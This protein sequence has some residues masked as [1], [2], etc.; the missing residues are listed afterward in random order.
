MADEILTAKELFFSFGKFMVTNNVY[1][2]IRRNE[3]R[4]IIGPNGAGKTTLFNL[5]TGALKPQ[6]GEVLFNG[7]NI[8]NI[9][10]HKRVGM[11]ISRSFQIPNI[12]PTLD[13]F[14]NLRIAVQSHL[15]HNVSL[16]ARADRLTEINER[17]RQLLSESGLSNKGDSFAG[18][19][20]HGDKRLLEISL[21]LGTNPQ[22]LLLDEPTAGLSDEETQKI[23]KLIK[24][25][26][27]RYTVIFV[28][29]DIEMVMSVAEKITV[30][31]QGGIVAEGS[32]DEIRK[33]QQVQAIYLG[34]D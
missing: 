16:F 32:P 28:E 1:L 11:G 2:T 14:E 25:F 8:T 15:R 19:L 31:H 17:T 26:S 33:N 23:S 3:T 29:H 34:E 10:V 7:Q 9:P 12:F 4:A 30:M 6:R 5:L 22:L 13:V 21:T 18:S 20:S 27:G 24:S